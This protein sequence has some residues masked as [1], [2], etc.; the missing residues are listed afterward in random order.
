[1]D[2]LKV[3]VYHN[4]LNISEEPSMD[5]LI[6]KYEEALCKYCFDKKASP[7]LDIN[8]LNLIVQSFEFYYMVIERQELKVSD[9]VSLR[10]YQF[11]HAEEIQL[12]PEEQFTKC[13]M[14]YLYTSMLIEAYG[15][16]LVNHQEIFF[17]KFM[18]IS[19]VLK[20]YEWLQEKKKKMN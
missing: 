16:D 2:N 13:D 19:K 4:I 12:K 5:A 11:N 7:V 15:N 17:K 6:E 20:E 3:A 10:Q 8:L 9:P 1:M 14:T 18:T